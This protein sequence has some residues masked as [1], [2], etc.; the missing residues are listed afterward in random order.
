LEEDL[1]AAE[2]DELD[3]VSTHNDE[4]ARALQLAK[5][6]VQRD[7]ESLASAMGRSDSAEAAAMV[8]VLE[9][10]RAGT[11]SALALDEATRQALDP[12]SGLDAADVAERHADVLFAALS[13]ATSRRDLA[14]LAAT[15]S[16]Y[17][18]RLI[19]TGRLD[20]L[21]AVHGA[22]LARIDRGERD[23]APARRPLT[24]QLVTAVVFQSD[25]LR[26]VAHAVATW[27]PQLPTEQLAPML[28]GLGRVTTV[29]SPRALPSCLGALSDLPDGP[30]L[31]LFTDYVARVAPGQEHAIV[32]ELEHLSPRTAQRL[33]ARLGTSSTPELR[34][35]LTTL[36][37]SPNATLRCEALA[38]LS[39]S[40]AELG[41]ELMKLYASDDAEARR[42]ALD[43]FVRHRLTSVGPALVRSAQDEGFVRK[44]V[45]ER[46]SLLEALQALHPRRTEGLLI[47]LLGRHGL[48]VDAQLDETRAL[49]ASKLGEWADTAAAAD[50]LAA[51]AR[52]R[53]WNGH[54]LREIATTALGVVAQRSAAR[55]DKPGGPP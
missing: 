50:A 37:T 26:Q 18:N 30:V 20:E 35:E 4:V 7:L 51:A 8:A 44:P 5:G 53:P 9:T 47:E 45:E 29:L 32:Q 40:S 14:P 52:L 25:V 11:V 13:D 2:T 12:E 42:A 55:G 49:A 17:A 27:A 10:A 48:M 33:L 38:A 54:K 24:A 3:E 36:L 28:E 22:L 19:R 41:T 43:T 46:E 6:S 21:F 34:A 15:F 31:T 1:P 39:P 16:A 23:A